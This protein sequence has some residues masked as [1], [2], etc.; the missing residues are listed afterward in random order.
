MGK[1]VVVREG[2]NDIERCGMRWVWVHGWNNEGVRWINIFGFSVNTW[3]WKVPLWIPC[4]QMYAYFK[5]WDGLANSPRKILLYDWEDLGANYIFFLSHC[6]ISKMELWKLHSLKGLK[7]KFNGRSVMI[8]EKNYD[9]ANSH[10]QNQ[11]ILCNFNL[12]FM[13]FIQVP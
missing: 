13:N 9:A 5:M 1:G 3:M 11:I 6:V 4:H 12:F 10:R 7:F 2:D 8:C